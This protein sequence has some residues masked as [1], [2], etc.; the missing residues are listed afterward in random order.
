[1]LLHTISLCL[2]TLSAC[3]LL[4]RGETA[5]LNTWFQTPIPESTLVASHGI[6]RVSTPEQAAVTA[7]AKLKTSQF[8]RIKNSPMLKVKR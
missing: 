5:E 4:P 1:M 3:S 8:T 2:F 6:E 7:F